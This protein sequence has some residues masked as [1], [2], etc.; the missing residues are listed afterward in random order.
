LPDAAVQAGPGRPSSGADERILEAAFE[1][2]EQ[3]GYAGLTTAKVAARSGHNKALISYHFGSK[4]GLVTAVAR[5][6][7]ERFTDE[8]VGSLGEPR[9]VEALARALVRELWRILDRDEG[10]AR[11]YLDLA[12]QSV[13]DP[14]IR[15][16]TRELRAS[17]T[18]IVEELLA[19]LVDAPPPSRRE[20]AAVY[21]MV[22]LEGLMLAWLD[23][24]GEAAVTYARDMF[25]RSAPA[26]VLG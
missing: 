23:R 3:D 10:L 9:D 13:V 25:V 22:G 20:A 16:V 11:L 15:A 8:L 1:V 7:F 24:R 21:L 14:E 19:G 6:V 5:R 18:R 2:L 4:H 26:A 17:H 12:S